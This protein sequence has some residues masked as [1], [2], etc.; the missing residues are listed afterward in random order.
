MAG[1]TQNNWIE[2]LS[3]IVIPRKL[4]KAKQEIAK[5]LVNKELIIM[6]INDYDND[7]K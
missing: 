7:D 2:C 3:F 1:I 5:Q 4:V 6:I